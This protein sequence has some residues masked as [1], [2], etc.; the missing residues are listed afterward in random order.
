MW[1]R[2]LMNPG[3]HCVC[4]SQWCRGSALVVSDAE[5]IKISTDAL[6]AH[7]DND[8]DEVRKNS[9][10]FSY[11]IMFHVPSFQWWC[12]CAMHGRDPGVAQSMMSLDGKS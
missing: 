8:V 1:L 3:V 12:E 10:V 9:L 11:M 2:L 6:F 5:T 4:V 7:S